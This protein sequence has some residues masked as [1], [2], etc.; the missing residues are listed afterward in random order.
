[1]LAAL[2]CVQRL[3][4]TLQSLREAVQRNSPPDLF[5]RCYRLSVAYGTLRVLY[6]PEDDDL[7]P[8]AQHRVAAESVLALLRPANGSP[9]S[10][11]NGPLPE[12]ATVLVRSRA[13]KASS[14][15]QDP[16]LLL[17]LTDLFHDRLPLTDQ[18]WSHDIP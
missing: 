10:T 8:V 16:A 1:V 14:P 2:P 6:C 4:A 15:S 5:E 3:A 12:A 17:D 18:V 13:Y 11:W 7:V 9:S